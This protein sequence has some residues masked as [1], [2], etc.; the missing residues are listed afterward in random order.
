M[1]KIF[2]LVLFVLFLMPVYA[3]EYIEFDS[4]Q[5]AK[6]F[7]L[8][9]QENISMPLPI[10]VAPPQNNNPFDWAGWVVSAFGGSILTLLGLWGAFN[11]WTGFAASLLAGAIKG[12][13]KLS[14][15]I[16]HSFRDKVN[17]NLGG[18]K[19]LILKS[20]EYQAILSKCPDINKY[21]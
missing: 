20:D 7:L 6:K 2:V 4:K 16:R 8:E 15:N 3:Q 10:V 11:K 17:E 14:G 1:K 18:D 19:I 13:L 12:W 5:E 21:C 9:H